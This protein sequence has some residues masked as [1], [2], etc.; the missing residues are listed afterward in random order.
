MGSNPTPANP[1]EKHAARRARDG[2]PAS[3]QLA[4]PVLDALSAATDQYGRSP[5][6]GRASRPRLHFLLAGIAAILV[7]TILAFTG[8]S[9]YRCCA[10]FRILGDATPAQR[11]TLRRELSS[12]AWE[13]LTGEDSPRVR[14]P[15][16][17]VDSPSPDQLRLTVITPSRKAGL[18]RVRQTAEGYSE[19]MRVLAQAARITPTEAE[20]T[21]SEYVSTLRE[22]LD[23]A[24]DR[25][26]AAVAALPESDTSE[27]LQLLMAHWEPLRDRFGTV[28]QELAQ[29]SAD[30]THLRSEPEPTHGVVSSEER[31]QA[32][33]ADEALQQDLR[34]LVVNLTELK[35][36]LLTVWQQSAGALERLKLA[37]DDVIKTAAHDPRKL[38]LEK[39]DAGT[40]TSI[41]TAANAYAE[42]VNAFAEAW[43][44]E[45]TTLRQLDIDPLSGEVLDVYYRVLRRLND[46]LFDASKQLSTL[47]AAVDV[48]SADPRD[49]ARH[50][51]FQSD[52]VRAFQTMQAAHHRFE[53][54]LDA[55]ETPQNFRLD[56]AIKSARGLHRRSQERIRGI[57]QRLQAQALKRAKEQRIQ[58]L[59]TVKE[60]F[61]RARAATDET[62]NELIALQDELN[63]TVKDSEAF[64]R[65]LL[66]VEIASARLEITNDDLDT[67]QQRLRELAAQ[68]MA[69]SNSLDVELVSCD[70][71]GGP[72][73]LG[74]RLSIAGL[75]A[76]LTLL[77]VLLTQWWIIR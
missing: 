12:Y 20:D 2:G 69:S 64:F 40:V 72:I 58:E 47:R 21:L 28:K 8:R 37:V 45:F 56:A 13:S 4:T 27:N 44:R 50:H 30:L 10:T 48:L 68:R 73:N 7:G 36:H 57:Q 1:R 60:V 61:D 66:K 43:S 11:V 31:Q 77:A 3:D 59:A 41:E 76:V 35:L 42:T 52:L 25:V 6:R 5:V 26:D 16:M 51:V 63:L 53:F 54:A 18:R 71:L 14:I 9:D 74:E 46:F 34:E 55:I 29:A 24:R 19:R 33:M 49:T 39:A 23:D 22:R 70:V 75:A 15:P 65:T 32:Q 62:V 17:H 38:E 67:T